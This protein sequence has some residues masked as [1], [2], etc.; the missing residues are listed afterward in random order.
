MVDLF[1]IAL[2]HGLMALAIW[3]LAQRADLDRDP[4]AEKPPR[5][6]RGKVTLGD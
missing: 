2:T 3:R 4:G 5:P 6:P 1:A